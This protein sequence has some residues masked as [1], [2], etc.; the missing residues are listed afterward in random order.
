MTVDVAEH[1]FKDQSLVWEFAWSAATGWWQTNDKRA[2][3]N[4]DE[5]YSW[6]G[7]YSA[8]VGPGGNW[9]RLFF[10][11]QATALS[12]WQ[13]DRAF[14]NWALWTQSAGWV[15]QGP[16]QQ[17]MVRYFSGGVKEMAVVTWGENTSS[18]QQIRVYAKWKNYGGT[19]KMAEYASDRGSWSVGQPLPDYALDRVN[20]A[21]LSVVVWPYPNPSTVHIRVYQT[22]CQVSGD[23]RA[24]VH[25]V[26]F[27]T[28][29]GWN[30]GKNLPA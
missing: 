10:W 12:S 26:G 2:L 29:S 4:T 28:S 11:D 9:I 23:C 27:D 19:L 20:Y 14:I 7:S 30:D 25:E 18:G 15:I 21:P 24:Y 16:I 1:F 17:D 3:L 6:G 22:R 8:I 13:N 5:G